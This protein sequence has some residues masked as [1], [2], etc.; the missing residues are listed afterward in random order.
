[1][2]LQVSVLSSAD[3]AK[4]WDEF[5]ER[6]EPATFF[7][8]SG[9]QQVLERAF[10][11]KCHFLYVEDNRE[12]V[13]VLPLAEVKSRLFGHN[14]SSLPFCVYGGIV[15]RDDQVAQLLRD[16][17]CELA[18]QL[19]V[20]SLELRNIDDNEPD[21]PGKSLY[22][23]FRKTIPENPDDCLTFIPNKQRAVVRKGIKAGLKSEEGWHADRI[24]AV[25]AESVRDLGTPIFS[26]GYFDV[27]R[28]VFGDRCRSLMI[29][30]EGSDVAG[31]LS[32]YFRDQVLPY[33]AGSTGASR[34]LHAHGFMY[35][36]LIRRSSE[37][38][39]RVFDFGRSKVGS[40]PYSFKKNWGFTPEPLHY[41]YHLIE[42]AG[43]PDV[44]PNNPKYQLFIRAWKKLPLPVANTVGPWLAR[45]LG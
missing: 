40:G 9:W 39:I 32:F 6:S 45:S 29:T 8:L 25:Y 42:A 43:I 26:R 19:K 16:H 12:I 27:L 3:K 22:A 44:N 20:D 4:Q 38:G 5:V 15:A 1:M 30:H 37:A 34:P 2:S 14:L 18:K 17:A 41:R 28:E 23:T 21:W 24:Y 33:Y 13:G 10:G 11:H 7:H 31:V 35:W 36:D